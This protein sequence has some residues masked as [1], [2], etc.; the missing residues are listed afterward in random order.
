MG[1]LI[2]VRN[3]V[4]ETASTS[5]VHSITRAPQFRCG[6]FG[7]TFL[8]NQ[9]LCRFLR[10]AWFALLST[11][12]LTAAAQTP[13]VRL[14][15][16]ISGPSSTTL[17]GSRPPLA[18]ISTDGGVLPSGTAV[19]GI[20]LVFARSAAQEADLQTLLAAQQDPSSAQYHQWLTPDTFAAR[21]GVAD[22]D[23]ATVETWLQGQGFSVESVNRSRNAVTFSG[24]AATVGS[25]FGTSLHRYTLNGESH[26]GPSSDLSLPATLAPVVAAVLHT[27]DFRP[28]PQVRL[29]HAQAASPDFTSSQS[30]P[31]A[32]YLTPKDIATMYNV[33]AEYNA[34]FTGVGQSIAVVGQSYI[35][36]ADVTAFRTAAGLAPNAPNL[37]L[38]PGT[39]V[40]GVSSGDEGESDLDLEYAGGMAPGATV[41][42]VYVGNSANASVLDALDYAITE[43]IAPVISISY[44]LCEPLTSLTSLNAYNSYYAQA[45][46]QGQT[47]VASAGD[48]GSEACY[49]YSNESTA[50]QEQL[51]VSF[52][53]SSPYV[54][55]V[56]GTQMTAGASA[57]GSTTYWSAASGA[58][59]VSS[60]LSYVPEVTWN[61]DSSTYGISA[62]GGGASIVFARPTWQ[63]GVTGIAA[64]TTRLVPDVSLLSAVGNPG[65]LYCSSD[66]TD[67]QSE[68]LTSSCTSGFRDS[69]GK[70]LLIAG[71]TSFAAPVMAGMTALLNQVKHATGQGLIN[72][73]L[74][75]LASNATTYASAF[76]D[77]TSGTNACTIGSATYCSVAGASVYAAGAGYDEA[78]GLGSLNFANLVAAWPSTSNTALPN[79]ITTLAPATGQPAAGTADVVTIN[80]TS[81]ST[82]TVTP[83]GT[84]AVSVD[85]GTATTVTLSNGS[86]S[87][88]YTASST[89][90]SHVITAL[91]SGDTV[92]AASKG[93]TTVTVTAGTVATGSFSLAATNLSVATGAS[94][95]S[96]VTATP[97]GGYTGSI[98]WTL[99]TGSAGTNVCYSIDA[100]PVLGTAA[101]TTT[102]LYIGVGTAVCG[103]VTYSPYMR[104][105][106]VVVQKAG[107]MPVPANRWKGKPVVAMFAGLLMTGFATR[108]RSRRLPTLL[109]VGVLAVLGIGLSGCSGSG[110]GE[111]TTTTPPTTTTTSYTLTLTGQDSVTSAITSSTTFTLTTH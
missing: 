11:F 37:V 20:T 40:S 24:T 16:P 43:N 38:V 29:A 97:S 18:A 56:G 59:V 89:G 35:T 62:G 21:F 6:R 81:T 52:P 72:P 14:R 74:Y 80:V 84:V 106:K 27:S 23:L 86:A 44:G 75:S 78:T 87:Y 67:L 94:G 53:A 54:T 39:G 8:L 57:A 76:H 32:H 34:G 31:Q 9:Q 22:A 107:L 55:G 58:D 42:L 2:C 25:A 19:K 105:V 110:T 71:G 98:V 1:R 109:A 60:L 3:F 108:R 46:T 7:E 104:P 77:I 83:T 103:S 12:C 30:S 48:A 17:T 70:Y 95:S 26:F 63:T 68:D 15:D 82:S 96:T 36:T 100:L 61:E 93:T 5:V 85:G 13:A 4:A 69:S 64:G 92:H 65:F 28:K 102:S 88:T 45:M 91:Y 51:A 79:T 101:T 99:S 47:I 41:Y 73:Q 66:L 50:V 49:G 111:T 10:P 33:Q 90:G